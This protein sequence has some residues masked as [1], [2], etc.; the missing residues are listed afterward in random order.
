MITR[1]KTDV[2]FDL[3]KITFINWLFLSALE[4]SRK[5]QSFFLSVEDNP[6]KEKKFAW[7]KLVHVANISS[8]FSF[9]YSF[10]Q[11]C[12]FYR[13]VIYTLHKFILSWLLRKMCNMLCFHLKQKI[14]LEVITLIWRHKMGFI[15]RFSGQLL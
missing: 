5:L 4:G 11:V 13:K 12:F 9:S 3:S 6:S 2:L 10:P 14:H 8:V 1:V 7:K 15:K